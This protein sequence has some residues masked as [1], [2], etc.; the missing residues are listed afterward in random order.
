MTLNLNLFRIHFI[1]DSVFTISKRP[2]ILHFTDKETGF[3][4]HPPCED[5]YKNPDP[6]LVTLKTFILSF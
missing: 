6:V 2:C 3:H 4:Q 5:Y 1:Y